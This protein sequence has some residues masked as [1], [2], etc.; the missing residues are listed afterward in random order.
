[1]NMREI[2]HEV[3][4][5]NVGKGRG[6]LAVK[7]MDARILERALCETLHESHDKPTK[8][9]FRCLHVALLSNRNMLIR[10]TKTADLQDQTIEDCRQA[11]I[12]LKEIAGKQ[13][14]SY[15]EPP[16]KLPE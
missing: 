12:C 11:V 9:F 15:E 3:A 1:M 13:G 6:H 4:F 5:A 7:V 2:I 10:D 14:V 8:K 16:D